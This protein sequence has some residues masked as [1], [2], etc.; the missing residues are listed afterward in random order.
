MKYE[1]LSTPAG[2]RQM[3]TEGNVAYSDINA[4]FMEALVLALEMEKDRPAGTQ[5][6][7]LIALKKIHS[8][9]RQVVEQMA[10]RLRLEGR[11]IVRR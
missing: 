2:V 3:I 9:L 1:G 4:K 10:S 7:D 8:E 11:A 5:K 6:Y